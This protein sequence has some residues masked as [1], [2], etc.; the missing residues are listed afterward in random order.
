MWSLALPNPPTLFPILSS[1]IY[2]TL[3]PNRGS[4]ILNPSPTIVCTDFL[5][6]PPRLLLH[7]SP[8]LS[9]NTFVIS[10][11]HSAS[12]PNC[13]IGMEGIGKFTTTARTVVTVQCSDQTLQWPW[14][15]SDASVRGRLSRD[16]SSRLRT[17]DRNRA[18]CNSMH[19]LLLVIGIDL[20]CQ[21]GVRRHHTDLKRSITLYQVARLYDCITLRS[22][23]NTADALSLSLSWGKYG[24]SI[25]ASLCFCPDCLK[26]FGHVFPSALKNLAHASDSRT[27]RTNAALIVKSRWSSVLPYCLPLY[28]TN[29]LLHSHCIDSWRRMMLI[30]SAVFGYRICHCIGLKLWNFAYG[31]NL[32]FLDH[33]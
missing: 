26:I 21:C 6:P 2:L 27:I 17:I 8:L 18:T 5:F 32:W 13:S 28:Y 15:P 19:L 16:T 10:R 29:L 30:V 23:I 1:P 25:H 33:E 22:W 12:P 4:E 9:P 20:A 24:A 31:T 11:P 7:A 14:D 3:L